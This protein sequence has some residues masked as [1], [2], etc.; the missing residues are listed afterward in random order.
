M[1]ESE[2]S[3]G[4]YNDCGRRG[5]ECSVVKKLESGEPRVRVVCGEKRNVGHKGWSGAMWGADEMGMG[6]RTGV[7]EMQGGGESRGNMAADAYRAIS[8]HRV[9]RTTGVPTGRAQNDGRLESMS[10]IERH[11]THLA[12]LLVLVPPF[13][14]SSTI[15]AVSPAAS[16]FA[17]CVS[18][19]S[20]ASPSPAELPSEGV[21]RTPRYFAADFRAECRADAC[22]LEQ[23]T[24]SEWR[25]SD[26]SDQPTARGAVAI[27]QQSTD[28]R[29][30]QEAIVRDFTNRLG[31]LDDLNQSVL[32]LEGV[33][34]LT[35]EGH[36]DKPAWL[37]NLGDSLLGHFERLGDLNQSSVLKYEAAV[38]LTPDG[39][40][41]KPSQLSNLGNSLR[42]CFEKLHSPRDSQQLLQHFTSA[43][44]SSTGPASIKFYAAT[45]WAK[46]AHFHDPSS[47]IYAYTTAIELL[48][49]L[50]WLGLSIT[51]R[52]H[53]LSQAGQVVR[54]AASAVI[55]VHDYEKAVVWLDQGRSVIWGQ[56]LNL[57]T[58][59]DELRKSHPH[60]A[61]QLVSLSTV[62]ET[63]GTRSNAVTDAIKPKSLDSIAEQSHTF[64]LKRHHV[65]Q[66]IRELP[67][68]ERPW[69]NLWHQLWE[70][71]D[72]VIGKRYDAKVCVGVGGAWSW[73]PDSGEMSIAKK[74]M[75]NFPRREKMASGHGQTRTQKATRVRDEM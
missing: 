26:D 50:A 64:A 51:D 60:L 7:V 22:S 66:Q 53:L 72:T 18:V 74:L 67:D 20:P 5:R 71:L 63:A 13:A 70:L 41:D 6:E 43:A 9:A 58:P 45:Q 33:V 14:F 21:R 28:T 8:S 27:F 32:R 3:G 39:H 69:P 25:K 68:F 34:N 1:D 46:H 57:R 29:R 16:C 36:L 44:C 11:A 47:I 30:K 65:L 37:N 12:L 31:G 61:D 2:R 35:P 62:L 15:A 4:G 73:P 54:D 19:T 23:R 42:Q 48:P 38:T 10:E 55:T 52:H 59:V 17:V 24:R 49:E 56:L 75:R 40:P